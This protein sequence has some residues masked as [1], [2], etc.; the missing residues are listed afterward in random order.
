MGVMREKFLS[1]AQWLIPH[2]VAEA[3]PEQVASTLDESQANVTYP[4][5]VEKLLG[6]ARRFR[7]ALSAA[8]DESRVFLLREIATEVVA[9]EL[10]LRDVDVR[11]VVARACERYEI[12]A[13]IAVRVHPADAAVV[14]L[15]YP[16][17]EDSELRRGDAIVEIATGTIDARLGVRLDRVLRALA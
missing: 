7:A 13:P 14:R 15:A 10:E 16:A 11:A 5:D 1:L 3:P 17:I 12:E 2:E 6:E 9:R 4:F 8:V